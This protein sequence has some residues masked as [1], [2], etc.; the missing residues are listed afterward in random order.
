MILCYI[1]LG[2][3]RGIYIKGMSDKRI[4]HKWLIDIMIMFKRIIKHKSRR[5]MCYFSYIKQIMSKAFILGWLYALSS[6]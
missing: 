3:V 1:V 2:H 4:M 5:I 6:I